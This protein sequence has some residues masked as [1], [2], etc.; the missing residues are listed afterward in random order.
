MHIPQQMRPAPLMHPRIVMVAGVEVTHQHPT[1]RL[2]QDFVD[3][4]LRASPPYEVPLRRGAEGPH[5]A[6][7]PILP[8]ARFIR[9]QSPQATADPVPYL[10]YSLF[11]SGR[12]S[13]NHVHQRPHTQMQLVE[14]L[15]MPLDLLE[16]QASLFP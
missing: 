12:R 14:R 11:R 8:P 16:G 13:M 5:V 15:Q 4:L 3:D 10:R 6:V 2:I 1:E 7:L 9:M